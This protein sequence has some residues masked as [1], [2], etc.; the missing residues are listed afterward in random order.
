MLGYVNSLLIDGEASAGLTDALMGL[1]DQNGYADPRAL[2]A[3]SPEPYATAL[4]MAVESGLTVAA[5]LRDIYYDGAEHQGLFTF[6][7]LL[8]SWRDLRSATAEGASSASIRTSGVIGGV[9]FT[10]E[11][12]VAGGFV[13][14]L[15]ARQKIRALSA[16]TESDGVVFGGILRLAHEGFTFGASLVMDRSTADTT[17]RSLVGAAISGAYKLHG[18]TFDSYVSWQGEVWD[19]WLVSPLLGIT[20]VLGKRGSFLEAGGGPLNMSVAAQNYRATF[21]FGEIQLKAKEEAAFQPFV[22]TGLRHRLRGD[23]VIARGGFEGLSSTYTVVGADRQKTLGYVRAGLAVAV[24]SAVRW[25]LSGE[26]EIGASG[27][28]RSLSSELR[29]A[30]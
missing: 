27:A 25:S 16:E 18:T 15:D 9:G 21:S 1:L 22:A 28:G 19:G 29:V 20:Q 7:K 17:R 24:S 6:G 14:Y 30:L 2:R 13:G 4:Q 3:L 11:G 23:E 12:F 10:R 5:S 26:S 8:G